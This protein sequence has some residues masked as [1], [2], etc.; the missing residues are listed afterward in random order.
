MSA[1]PMRHEN[2]SLDT[3]T[4]WM[5]EFQRHWECVVLHMG[6]GSIIL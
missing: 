6:D 1:V 5:G 3:F 2:V 4:M